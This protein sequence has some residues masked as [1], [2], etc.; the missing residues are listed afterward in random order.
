MEAEVAAEAGNRGG[1]KSHTYSLVSIVLK[2]AAGE[3][4][5]KTVPTGLWAIILL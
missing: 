4:Q 2:I 3:G 5:M 1:W